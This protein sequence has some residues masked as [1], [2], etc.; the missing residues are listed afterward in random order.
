M[1]ILGETGVGKTEIAELIHESSGRRGRR[2]VRVHATDFMGA[3]ENIAKSKLVGYG[4][5]PTVTGA[6]PKGEKG[7]LQEAEGGTL[8]IDEAGKLPGWSRTYLQLVIDRLPIQLAFGDGKPYT[9]D[10]R[11]I[12]AAY[13]F[14][15][16]IDEKQIAIDFLRR[17]HAFQI[18]IP[19]LRER[20]DDIL[21]FVQKWCD[22]FRWTARFLGCLLKHHWPGN[23]GE[24]RDVLEA[25]DGQM[26]REG[27]SNCGAAAR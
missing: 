9:P 2:F 27:N 6:S 4:K 14:Q 12:F 10:V 7:R 18:L 26:S 5:N 16:R 25:G 15:E 17:L 1:L 8:F 3:D 23:V 11:L 21:C 13:D 19:P 22:G 24:L 20:R